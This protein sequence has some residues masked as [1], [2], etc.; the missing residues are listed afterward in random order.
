MRV[1]LAISI[2]VVREVVSLLEMLSHR[3]LVAVAIL[4]KLNF[5]DIEECPRHVM[6]L[7][8][9]VISVESVPSVG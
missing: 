7:E 2:I 8:S 3:L 1:N 9:L 5:L 6:V 4:R